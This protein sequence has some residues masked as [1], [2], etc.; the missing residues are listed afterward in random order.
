MRSFASMTVL[1]LLGCLTASVP[2]R[3]QPAPPQ[4][5]AVRV[6]LPAGSGAKESGR[7]RPGSWTPVYVKIKASKAGNP[8]DAFQV[9][10][11][12]TDPDEAL[13]SYPVSLPA[14][15]AN[16]DFL[17]IGYVRPGKESGDVKV[18]LQSK[19]GKVLQSPLKGVRDSGR[20]TVAPFGPAGAV[21]GGPALQPEKSPRPAAQKARR[22]AG[23][24]AAVRGGSGTAPSG[25]TGCPSAAPSR[26]A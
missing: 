10:V 24:A 3:A 14:L 18:T 2:A 21:R 4:I 6:G 11:Q 23:P 22:A 15:A 19:D 26:A 25:S 12:A 9:I 8:R 7:V 17:A 20:E 13:Y 1:A 5:E 16:Q